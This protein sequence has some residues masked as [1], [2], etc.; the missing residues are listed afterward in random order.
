MPDTNSDDYILSVDFLKDMDKL[1]KSSLSNAIRKFIKTNEK[2]LVKFNSIREVDNKI[3][4]KFI[5]DW[6]NN[7][8]LSGVSL[9]NAL[10]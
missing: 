6:S 2:Y 4:F 5:E 3:Y 10:L 8:E 1:K 7:K 9:M